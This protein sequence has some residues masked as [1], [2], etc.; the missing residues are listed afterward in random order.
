MILCCCRNTVSFSCAM[1]YSHRALPLFSFLFPDKCGVFSGASFRMQGSKVFPSQRKKR[2]SHQRRGKKRKSQQQQ[3]LLV[4]GINY[5]SFLKVSPM[6]YL[7]IRWRNKAEA[8]DLNP[9]NLQ[10]YSRAVRSFTLPLLMDGSNGENGAGICCRQSPSGS[11]TESLSPSNGY[12]FTSSPPSLPQSG[13]LS[14]RPHPLLAPTMPTSQKQP[15]HMNEVSLLSV[16][17]PFPLFFWW[18]HWQHMTTLRLLAEKGGGKGKFM[19]LSC[20]RSH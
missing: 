18:K 14:S 9:V 2:T 13:S 20:L 1:S 8:V 15:G 19:S 7:R 17:V 10:L 4:A 12:P 6:C 3:S 5:S 11:E 16:L